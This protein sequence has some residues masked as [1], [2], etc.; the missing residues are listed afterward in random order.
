MILITGPQGSGN[1]MF[2]KLFALHPSVLGWKSLNE[3]YWI[4]HDQE[5]F[6]CLWVDPNSWDSFDFGDYQYAVVGISCP[7]VQQGE[8]VLPDYDTFIDSAKKHGWDVQVVVIGRDVNV[9]G[10]QQQRVRTRQTFP[11]MIDRLGTML[12]KYEPT[13]ISHESAVLYGSL[14]LK[15]LSCSWDFPVA[16]DD[17]R[18]TEILSE[19]A[20]QKYFHP[21]EHH[22]LDDVA[23][24]CTASTSRPGTEWYQRDK[25]IKGESK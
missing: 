1:H 23:I 24:K 18:V 15:S 9:L 22:W 11:M 25:K 12:D 7:Y 5:P 4:G 20:N 19:N 8:T 10:F 21:V 3:T 16:W 13:F 6:N 2:A 14:Y 17:P